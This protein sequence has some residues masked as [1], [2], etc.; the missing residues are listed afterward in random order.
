MKSP[1]GNISS[2]TSE[3]PTWVPQKDPDTNPQC[4]S[5][6][7][8][9]GKHNNSS[10]KS[11]TR[12]VGVALIPV[13]THLYDW[14]M[15]P[16]WESPQNAYIP[17]NYVISKHWMKKCSQALLRSKEYPGTNQWHSSLCPVIVC[18][19]KKPEESV[20]LDRRISKN[21]RP[22]I[23]LYPNITLWWFSNWIP[24]HLLPQCR[25]TSFSTIFCCHF[26]SST[27]TRKAM[28]S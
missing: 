1:L 9:R 15:L 10:H 16:V 6:L 21:F 2:T 4:L 17:V 13:N 19:S 7:T 8:S 20:F 22:S 24:T 14:F 18:Y 27:P 26:Y 12:I 28:L 3:N 23:A 11:P 25:S 5:L